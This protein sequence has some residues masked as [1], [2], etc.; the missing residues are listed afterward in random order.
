MSTVPNLII[1]YLWYLITI[2]LFRILLFMQNSKTSKKRSLLYR[3]SFKS[4]IFYLGVVFWKYHCIKLQS[5]SCV[6]Y[7]TLHF[8]L[9]NKVAIAYVTFRAK[10]FY[11]FSLIVYVSF[12]PMHN[13][14]MW[15]PK[16]N[17]FGSGI[18]KVSLHFPYIYGPFVLAIPLNHLY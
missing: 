1:T 4:T 15:Q 3:F 8:T 5:S 13:L 17:Q 14:R 9:Y 7:K 2:N 11:L 12:Y 18:F 16:F 10:V 6:S